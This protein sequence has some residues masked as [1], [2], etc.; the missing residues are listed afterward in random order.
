M[1]KKGTILTVELVEFSL[2]LDNR[3]NAGGGSSKFP[4]CQSTLAIT[5]IYLLL[6][7]EVQ[8]E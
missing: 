6:I 4:Y 5:W 3:Y 2:I 8:E 1:Y 7:L